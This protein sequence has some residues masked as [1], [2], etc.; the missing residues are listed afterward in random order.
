MHTK[1]LTLGNARS[2]GSQV[3]SRHH[4]LQNVAFHADTKGAS[5]YFVRII[6]AYTEHVLAVRQTLVSPCDGPQGRDMEIQQ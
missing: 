3:L 2:A 4:A 6:S 5:T 1:Q